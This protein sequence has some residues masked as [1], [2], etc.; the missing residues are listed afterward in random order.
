MDGSVPVSVFCRI[1]PSDGPAD[2][3]LL[4]ARAVTVQS[5][6]PSPAF[7]FA[8]VFG[9]SATQS[10]VYDGVGVGAVDSI[11]KGLNAVVLFYGQTGSGKT[12]TMSGDAGIDAEGIMPRTLRE[13]FRRSRDWDDVRVVVSAIEIYLDRLRDLVCPAR[14][15]DLVVRDGGDPRVEGACETQ[16]SS[17]REVSAILRVAQRNRTVRETDMNDVSSRAHTI[18]SV[19][20]TRRIERRIRTARLMLI[21]LAGS[22]DVAKSG[23]VGVRGK[24]ACSTNKSLL[25]LGQVITALAAGS[26]HAPFRDS[27]LTHIMQSALGGNSVVSIVV[28]LRSGNPRETLATLN[29]GQSALQVK[30]RP[31]TGDIVETVAD[32]VAELDSRSATVAEFERT[33][34]SVRAE[35]AEMAAVTEALKGAREPA[36]RPESADAQCGPDEPMEFDEIRHTAASVSTAI[37][38]DEDGGEGRSL[39]RALESVTV[40]MARLR[41]ASDT[42]ARQS[43]INRALHARLAMFDPELSSG[44]AKKRV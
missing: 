17:S 35:M 22:E 2:I 24:E 10:D 18:F 15:A 7:E 36:P 19:T 16:V 6:R 21:D 39:D 29:F 26:A 13:I 20:V 43:C 33:L 28:T 1:R 31:V 27:K 4:G 38:P 5:D 12:Y 41:D 8:R 14:S 30:T 9:P 44:G 25:A 23:A 32:L 42:I 34:A 40:M 3:S 37:R 11:D